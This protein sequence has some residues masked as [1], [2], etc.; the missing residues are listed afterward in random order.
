MW[1]EHLHTD[2]HK[3]P[4]PL[5]FLNPSGEQSI[6]NTT[7]ELKMRY[8]SFTQGNVNLYKTMYG[9]TILTGNLQKWFVN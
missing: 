5:R 2:L 9:F 7:R 3:C 6:Y 1:P 4:I 8:K